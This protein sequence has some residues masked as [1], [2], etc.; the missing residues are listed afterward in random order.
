V[1]VGDRR[2]PREAEQVIGQ[3]IALYRARFGTR[4]LRPS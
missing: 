4:P 1:S 3:A 2:G